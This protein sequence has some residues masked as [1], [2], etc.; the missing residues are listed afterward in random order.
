[1]RRAIWLI[2]AL[3]LLVVPKAFAWRAYNDLCWADDQTSANITTYTM[4]D[5]GV[6]VNYDTGDNTGVSLAIQGGTGPYTN[7]GAGASAG[8]DAHTVFNGIV[9]CVG[10]ISYSS[11]SNLTFTFSGLDANQKYEVVI[12]G[13]RNNSSYTE[14][15]TTNIISGVDSFTN[16]STSGAT[17]LTTVDTDDTTVICNGYNTVNGYVARY[18]NIDPGTDGAFVVTLPMWDGVAEHEQ[19][20][21]YAN[22]LMLKTLEC[23]TVIKLSGLK[24]LGLGLLGALGLVAAGRQKMSENRSRRRAEGG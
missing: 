13:N 21:Y 1:M 2:T 14:R 11:T 24:W 23:G 8:T 9:D 22:A 17:V 20:R 7:Q 15:T 5:S 19:G 4:A 18:S 3:M 10:V 6:L 16:E 12:F